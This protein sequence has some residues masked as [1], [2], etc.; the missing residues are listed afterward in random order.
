VG[1]RYV[2][3]SSSLDTVGWLVFQR[4][5]E[6]ACFARRTLICL[7]ILFWSPGIGFI[8]DYSKDG[9]G[10]RPS[11]GAPLYSGDYFLPGT[12]LEGWSVEYRI[13]TGENIRLINKGLVGK[14]EIPTTTIE[15]THGNQRLTECLLL[16]TTCRVFCIVRARR[17]PCTGS[18]THKFLFPVAPC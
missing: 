15:G 2:A 16:A 18:L 8:A 6:P 11:A 14:H 5:F 9:F 10:V 17:S 13:G 12:P 7:L 4:A 1:L 3:T